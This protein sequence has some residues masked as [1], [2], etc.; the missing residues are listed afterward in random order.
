MKP[1]NII[2]VI[3]FIIVMIVYCAGCRSQHP[4]YKPSVAITETI[5][6]E[7][8]YYVKHDEHLTAAQRKRRYTLM[9]NYKHALKVYKETN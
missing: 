5:F 9:E 8:E 6:P 1:L 3:F 7:Y 2:A 4:L